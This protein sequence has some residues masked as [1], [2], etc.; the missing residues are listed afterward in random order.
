MMLTAAIVLGAAPL[1]SGLFRALRTGSDLRL[2]WMALAASIFAAGVLATEFGRRQTR[3][4][5]VNQAL[6]IL[7]VSS[8]LAVGTGLLLGAT[9]GPGVWMVA[10]VLGICLAVSSVLVARSR[11]RTG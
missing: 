9:A 1:G 6:V 5:I 10:V 2:L 7:C 8:A 3:R 4:A 11:P